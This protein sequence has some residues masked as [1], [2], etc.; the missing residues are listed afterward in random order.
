[1][2][3]G[4]YDGSTHELTNKTDLSDVEAILHPADGKI[5]ENL[6]GDFDQEFLEGPAED[7]FEDLSKKVESKDSPDRGPQ[8]LEDDDPFGTPKKKSTK[9]AE[10]PFKASNDAPFGK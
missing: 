6:F 1:M 4:M 9:K 2:I 5:P 8:K 7:G 10:D 3:V